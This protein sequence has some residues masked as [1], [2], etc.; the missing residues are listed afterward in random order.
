MT[1]PAHHH[2]RRLSHS[3]PTESGP[4]L[5]RTRQRLT[6][7]PASPRRDGTTNHASAVRDGLAMVQA[8]QR[9]L[10]RIIET[11]RKQFPHVPSETVH[12]TVEAIHRRFIGASMRGYIRVL[13][14]RAA[15]DQLSHWP[16]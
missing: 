8:E 15:Q 10:D 14:E 3:A 9:A 13:V 12:G 4:H 5:S 16:D 1:Q 6:Q 2:P 11:L 7:T